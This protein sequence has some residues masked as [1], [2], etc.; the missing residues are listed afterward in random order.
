M[1]FTKKVRL[2]WYSSMKKNQKDFNNFW[3]RKFTLK[4]Q[5]W[6]FLTNCQRMETQIL[7]ISFDYSWFLAKNLA[8]EDPYT[9]LG[10]KKIFTKYYVK[11][12]FLSTRGGWGVKI[13]KNLA[14]VVFEW[15]LTCNI[16]VWIYM[17]SQPERRC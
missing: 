11:Y 9:L 2:N 1:L 14:H 15:P 12:P 3:H 7:V 4:V 16:H 5:N 6:H 17:V 13:V 10:E 8:F